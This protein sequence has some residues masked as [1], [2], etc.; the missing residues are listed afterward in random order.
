MNKFTPMPARLSA[1]KAGIFFWPS[2]FYPQTELKNSLS[3]C[4]N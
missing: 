1:D 4:K 3:F 2:F